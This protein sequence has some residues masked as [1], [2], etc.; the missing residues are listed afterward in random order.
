V[1]K[2]RPCGASGNLISK[3]LGINKDQGK[4]KGGKSEKRGYLDIGFNKVAR[5]T[6]YNLEYARFGK[7]QKSTKVTI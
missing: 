1:G 6:A 5:V 4:K 7:R 2:I 3:P